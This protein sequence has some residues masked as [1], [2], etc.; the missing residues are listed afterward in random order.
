MNQLTGDC[1]LKSMTD[2]TRII[3]QIEHGDPIAV[4]QLLPLVDDEL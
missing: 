1:I 3:S 4:E 2:V